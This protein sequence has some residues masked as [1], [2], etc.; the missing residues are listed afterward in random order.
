MRAAFCIL[1]T[2]ALAGCVPARKP[3]EP[4]PTHIPRVDPGQQ[5]NFLQTS[6]PA[7]ARFSQ[8]E[9][10]APSSPVSGTRVTTLRHSGI[11][12]EGVAFDSRTHRLVVVDQPGGPGSRFAD[13]AAAGTSRGGVA[14]INAS[15]FTPE[16]Q[17]LGL[18]IGSG[19]RAGFWNSASS[20]G[21]A[22]WYES[23][24]SSSIV[25][26]EALGRA[27]ALAM[28]ELVQAGPLLV[29]GGSPVKGL[30]ASKNSVRSVI[31]WDG[32]ARWWI[33][34]SSPCTLAE[35]ASALAYSQPG[36]WSVKQALNL[37]GGRSSDLWISG[38]VSGGPVTR[39]SPFNRPV[40]N[41]LVLVGK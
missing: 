9:V 41:F 13:A 38:E 28:R 4:A 6:T 33:G 39:R 7:I 36:G 21:S 18:A 10:V 14:A 12:F 32:G 34:R 31:L 2:M 8:P 23:G 22:L 35:L 30:D 3:S 11:T 27:G 1:V 5:K 37:D 20:L 16:G 40:R 24:S 26:R 15:F 17:V 19:N 29:D 25:R